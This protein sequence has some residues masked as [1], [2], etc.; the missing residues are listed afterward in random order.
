LT[1]GLPEGDFMLVAQPPAGE[2]VGY[3]WGGLF[4]DAIYHG[5]LR[6]IMVLPAYQGRGIGARLLC[7]V[8]ERLLEQQIHNMRVEVLYVNPNRAFYER[9][10]G[11]FIEED[12]YDWDGVILPRYVYSWEDTHALLAAKCC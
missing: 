3:A 4:N 2:V 8:A 6:Q 1:Q 12:L 5:E 9:M 10:G 11:V 7:R